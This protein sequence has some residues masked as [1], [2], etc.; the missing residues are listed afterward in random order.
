MVFTPPKVKMKRV[1]VYI[2]Q[3]LLELLEKHPGTMSEHIRRAVS[4]YVVK[5]FNVSTSPT[6]VH[7]DI[8]E[9]HYTEEGDSNDEKEK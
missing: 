3:D 7:E 6:I 5:L 4:E 8:T 9:T 2:P 1:N